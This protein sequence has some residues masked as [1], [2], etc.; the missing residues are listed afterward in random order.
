MHE[1]FLPIMVMLFTLL[2]MMG[3]VVI[4]KGWLAA[5]DRIVEVA[6]ASRPVATAHSRE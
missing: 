1:V 3:L 2:V 6:D 4:F 5:R